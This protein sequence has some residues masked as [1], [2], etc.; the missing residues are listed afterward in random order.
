MVRRAQLLLVTGCLAS[1]GVACPD[2]DG[3][4]QEDAEV[5]GRSDG[6]A[7]EDGG[8]TDASAD[9]S[10]DGAAD[11]DGKP[12]PTVWGIV[13]NLSNAKPLPGVRIDAISG[14][15]PMSHTIVDQATTDRDGRYELYLE[16]GAYTLHP[17]V[18]PEEDC[19]SDLADEAVV[20]TGPADS[21]EVSFAYVPPPCP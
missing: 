9:G 5:D 16:P 20:V 11:G 7:E 1:F 17:A 2:S 14:T 19:G 15:T 4:G 10:A 3:D 12:A 21:H 13:S 6:D 8:G 18:P